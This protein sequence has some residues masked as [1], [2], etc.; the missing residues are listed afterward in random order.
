MIDPASDEVFS[1]RKNYYRRPAA[2][3]VATGEYSGVN[4]MTAEHTAQ[5]NSAMGEETF[6]RSEKYE[7]RFQDV[8]LEPES[9]T[10]SAIDVLSSTTTME[11]GIDIGSL[12]GVALRNVPPARSNYQQRAGRAGRRANS[13]ATVVS[14]ASSDSHDENYFSKPKD[15][16]SG[17]PEEPF[18]NLDN[19]QIIRRHVLAFLLQEFHRAVLSPA[20][21]E[22]NPRLFDVLGTVTEFLDSDSQFNI[23]LFAKWSAEN[24]EEIADQLERWLPFQLNTIEREGLVSNFR[25]NALNDINDSIQEFDLE[26]PSDETLQNED[27]NNDQFVDDSDPHELLDEKSGKQDRLLDRLMDRGALPRYAFP[28]DVASLYVFDLSS[29]GNYRPIF[30]YS[31]SQGL[32]AALSQ[33]APG[34][35]VWIDNKMWESSA[36]YSPVPD[37]RFQAWA[38]RRFYYECNSCGYA[39]TMEKEQGTLREKTV[40]DACGN[41]EEMEQARW[42]F[43]P[44]GFAHQYGKPPITARDDIPEASYATR[45]KL[46]RPTPPDD[47]WVELNQRLKVYSRPERLLV[48]NRGAK[49]F[50]YSY[51]T[52]CGVIEP[53]IKSN[54]VLAGDHEKPF[55]SHG[56]QECVGSMISRGLVLGTDFL[57]DVALLSI[58]TNNPVSL[59]PG[60]AATNS[61]LR[62]VAESLSSSLAEILGIDSG[63]IQ[64]EFRPALT[65][66]GK[67]GGSAEI[68][69]YDTLAGGAG[70][71]AKFV[72]HGVETLE[73]ALTL[74]KDCPSNCDASCYRCMRSYR[75][76]FEHRLLN[77]HVGVDLVQFLLTG[78][79]PPLRS[80]RIRAAEAVLV[81]DLTRQ[82]GGI[83]DFSVDHVLDIPVLGNVE[84]PVWIEPKDGSPGFGIAVTSALTPEYL[85][86]E[87]EQASDIGMTPI[88]D[89]DESL[90]ALNLPEA[91]KRVGSYLAGH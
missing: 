32:P 55:P 76:K 51:C 10:S 15:M 17:A 54:S 82:F 58:S 64:A 53:A 16:I 86:P 41:T 70:Y 67:T 29:E 1:T 21:A 74:L 83:A 63:E 72:E 8:D 33:Y 80:D 9:M 61:I 25:S 37:E 12:S 44:P 2:E 45:A 24:E 13:V 3:A 57:T 30:E 49:N 48:T 59:R 68:Y 77:R 26:N 60:M 7:L 6:S 19:A 84:I 78:E 40:C 46:S 42:W 36:I 66:E 28:T 14:F 38:D 35:E 69:L 18:I 71:S 65:D 52:T 89:V 5:L 27:Q 47:E 50:G 90:I 11:V 31:P 4:L 39:K 75:N 81:E 22:Q 56:S 88:I 87:I 73:N 43:R 85:G 34:K 62:T 23:S 20:D 79:L 91:V